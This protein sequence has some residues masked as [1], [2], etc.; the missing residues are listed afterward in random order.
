[1]CDRWCVNAISADGGALVFTSSA[2]ALVSG[3]RNGFTDVY[4][5]GGAHTY[6][7]SRSRNGSA[8][9]RSEG[10]S[11]SADGRVVAFRSFASN[12]VPNDTNRV[13]D[14]FVRDRL[15]GGVQRLSVSSSG[16]QAGRESFRGMVSADGRFVGFRSVAG[17]LVQGDTNH[18]IDV[19]VHDRLSA[20]T[21]RISV[22]SDGVQAE[23]RWFPKVVR[24][25]SFQSRP[26][27]SEH[28]RYAAFT[29]RAPNL[30]RGDT[31]G[32][33]DVF[34]H[35]LETG[36]TVRVSVP[37]GGG[38]AISDSRVTG[39]SADGSV[40]GF[41]SHAGNLV[42]GDTNRRNDYFVRVIATC[43]SRPTGPV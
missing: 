1:V 35:D 14:V 15:T 32:R 29:S 27:L 10:S 3:D 41:M 4:V 36:R 30:V 28:G 34:R 22:A 7:I 20:K 17:N 24:N 2:D 13:P 43:G 40:V 38:Q 33:A 39:I 8:N 25:T 16:A 11:I 21:S 31:N 37:D 19:F 12:L 18:A 23:A 9:G 26:F 42:P 6:L 5:Q